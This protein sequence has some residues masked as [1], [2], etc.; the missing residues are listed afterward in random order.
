M[1]MP[2]LS[3]RTMTHEDL[4]LVMGWACE[5]NWNVGKHDV[6]PYYKADPEGYKLLLL[7]NEPIGSISIVKH[8]NDFAFIGLF[9]IRKEYRNQ[10]HGTYLFNAAITHLKERLSAKANIGLYAV[11]KEI[12]RYQKFGFKDIFK[13][14]Q[15]SVTAPGKTAAETKSS[16]IAEISSLFH[17]VVE[18]DKGIFSAPRDVL[19][20]HLLKM[21]GTTAFA[22]IKENKIVGYG[23][24][25]LCQAGYRIGPLYANSFCSAKIL[26]EDLLNSIATSKEMMSVTLDMP[27]CNKF[28]HA[29][30]EYFNLTQVPENDTQAMFKEVLPEA[31]SENID[32]NYAVCS[33]ELG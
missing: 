29:L 9:I 10:G 32:K 5:E 7:D 28:T 31:L 15:W 23:I 25:R 1:I 26:L 30:A 22:H 21:P 4:K 2:K 19:L 33:L 20:T 18:Y 13:N 24:I 12:T 3:M 14:N 16:S 8:S 11:P 17:E 6:T 27:E